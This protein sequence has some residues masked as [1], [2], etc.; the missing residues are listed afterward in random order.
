MKS[1]RNMEQEINSLKAKLIAQEDSSK[2]KSM[3]ME[4]TQEFQ[5]YRT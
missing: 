1:V 3:L 4:L 5:D 2:L